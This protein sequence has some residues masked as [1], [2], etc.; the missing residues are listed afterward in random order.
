MANKCCKKALGVLLHYETLKIVDIKNKKVG[1]VFRL[2]QLI[3]LS[4]VIGYVIIYKKGYQERDTAISTVSTKLKGT[5][6]VNFSNFS[7]IFNGIQTYDSSDYVIPPQ[8][9]NG[10]FVMTNMV[11]TPKQT[12]GKC[13][14]DTKFKDNWCFSDEDCQP[15]LEVVKNG[16]GIRT[17]ACVHSQSKPSIKVCEIYAWCP[18]EIDS[19]PMPGHNFS[20]TVSLLDLAKDF[21]V[22]VKNHINFPKFGVQRRN[23]IGYESRTALKKCTYNKENNTRCPIFKLRDILEY[24]GDNFTEV[25]FK[26]GI[27]GILIHWDCNLDF[28]EDSCV[29]S[30]DFTRL[31]DPDAP[32]SPGYNFRFS[33]YFVE[34]NKRY[35]T[36]TKAFGIKFQVL[37]NAKA[38]KFGPVPL[39]LNLGAGFALLG[40]AKIWCDFMVLYCLKKRKIYKEHKFDRIDDDA[41]N[42]DTADEL[43]MEEEELAKNDQYGSEHN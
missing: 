27:F 28:S 23:I 26:G 13:P 19:L 5:A 29:P 32:I 11:I 17:G 25:A 14:E 7:T 20:K 31:D 34:N 35:R 6:F 30:Y 42:T 15:P 22:L 3:I 4:Y 39:F 36:L 33:D 1:A 40:L 18:T 21:T 2:I 10:F 24:V 41:D 12:Q 37:V 16:N 8:E 38:G 43:S 9:T